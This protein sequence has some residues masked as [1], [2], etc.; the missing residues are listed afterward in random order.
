MWRG[1]AALH[2]SSVRRRG[3]EQQ[4]LE[5]NM[6]TLIKSALVA[7]ALAVSSFAVT[8]PAA[9]QVSFGF[10]YGNGYGY[11]NYYRGRPYA[12]QYRRNCRPVTRVRYDRFGYRHFVRTVVCR[13]P[14]RGY[15]YRG[16]YGYGY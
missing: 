3:V 10:S 1:F 4:R 6:K 16:G 12:T 13:P 14:A 7:G 15:G 9:A 5:A 11:D 8:T 2:Q